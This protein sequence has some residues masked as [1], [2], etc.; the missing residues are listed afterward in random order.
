[1]LYKFLRPK[2]AAGAW[3]TIAAT[4]ARTRGAGAASPGGGRRLRRALNRCWHY[5]Q[6][7]IKDNAHALKKKQQQI[8]TDT[9]TYAALYTTF[10][11]LVDK[12]LHDIGCC[13]RN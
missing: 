13:T 11:I 7:L 10:I 4:Q 5:L 12:P 2:L 3:T 1:M 8:S 6:S 9:D